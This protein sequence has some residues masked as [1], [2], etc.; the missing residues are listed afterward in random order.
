MKVPLIQDIVKGRSDQ[1]P[2]LIA[3]AMPDGKLSYAEL[4]GQSNRF[5]RMIICAGCRNGDRI[6]LLMEK[7]VEAVISMIGCMKAGCICIPIPSSAPYSSLKKLLKSAKPDYIIANT[8][9][10]GSLLNLKNDFSAPDE[11]VSI[12]WMGREDE[13]LPDV[14]PEFIFRNL[15]EYSPN[16][17]T[18]SH[19]PYNTVFVQL[20]EMAGSEIVGVEFIHQDILLY[21]IWAGTTFHIQSGDR[22]CS[23]TPFHYIHFCLDMMSTFYAGARLDLVSKRV[24]GRTDEL[25][26]TFIDRKI[27]HGVVPSSLLENLANEKLPGDYSKS[28][29]RHLMY[30]DHRGSDRVLD[31]CSSNLNR[32]RVTNLYSALKGSGGS[33]ATNGLTCPID[34]YAT[35]NKGLN[36]Y[37]KE[38]SQPEFST[39]LKVPEGSRKKPDQLNRD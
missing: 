39:R 1:I 8:G 18:V 35:E 21:A 11:M 6:C 30:W 16:E 28:E 14:C 38:N 25:I 24:V 23:L 19:S 32:I 2:D 22:I 10:S 33:Q 12:G 20:E 5:A 3:L 36:N 29:L 4:E 9:L 7:K 34:G 17:L 15:V 13:L 37:E 26:Q 31:I 27:T